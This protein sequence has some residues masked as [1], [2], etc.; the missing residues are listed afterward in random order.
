MSDQLDKLISPKAES[1]PMIYAYSDISYPNCLKVGYTSVDV[2]K[3]VAQQYPTK[4][5]DGLVPYRIVLRE[6]AM[7]SDGSSFMDHDVHRALRKMGI[8]Q[9]GDS[10]WFKCS[11]ND[12]K[13]AIVAVKTGT[14][15]FEKCITLVM[16]SLVSP[17]LKTYNF[18]LVS[19]FHCW[20]KNNF[21]YCFL[22][23]K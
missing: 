14:R 17:C 1:K 11:V 19:I 18:I 15:N 16:F 3:R 13:A 8:K 21:S 4:R 12:V 22:F 9:L 20:E 23:S 7:L 6:S 10:E 5:P 2:D